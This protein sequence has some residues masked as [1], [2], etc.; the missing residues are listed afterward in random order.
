MNPPPRA[1]AMGH[2]RLLFVAAVVK[3][4]RVGWFGSGIRVAHYLRPIRIE[5]AR[6]AAKAAAFLRGVAGRE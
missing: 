1:E 5:L 2:G 4:T 6:R 3:L